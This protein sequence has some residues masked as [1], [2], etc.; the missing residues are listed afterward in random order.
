VSKLNVGLLR[1]IG[2]LLF[3]LVSAILAGCY[4]SHPQSTFDTLGPVSRSQLSLFYWIFWAAVIVFVVV[5]SA[6]I[7]ALIRYRR[8]SGD[9]DPPQ[10]HGHTKLEIIWTI[11]PAII[12]A[13]IAVPTVITV[14]DNANSPKS[15]VEGGMEVDVTA[16]QW[17]WE[18]KYQNP[19]DPKGS[20]F[21]ANELY[22]PEDEVVNLNLYSK[23]VLHSFWIPKLA[24]KVDVVPNHQNTIWI[25]ADEPG[26]YLGQC[27]EFCGVAHALMRFHVIAKSR[28]E[29]DEWL[30]DQASSAVESEEPLALEGRT[31][32]E[33]EAQCYACHTVQ[34]SDRS[35]GRRGPDLTL[36][37]SRQHIAAGI[38]ENNQENLRRWLTNPDKIKP[39]NLMSREASVFVEPEK[40]LSERQISALVAYL[41]TL[42]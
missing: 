3:V 2:L 21:T 20:V 32:F 16:H 8:K 24:G 14:F 13:V 31:L 33:G 9:G 38:L 12:L 30:L 41:Q 37:A 29:F 5:V 11:L 1:N 10:I 26:V 7:Y 28:S 6:L 4:P 25:K 17:F 22:I 42:E 18:F 23:D 19:N 27:A 34:G 39:G 40:R 15:P 36:L 35:K